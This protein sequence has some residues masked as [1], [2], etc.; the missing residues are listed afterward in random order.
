MLGLRAQNIL[1]HD[2]NPS[3]GPGQA[4]QPGKAAEQYRYYQEILFRDSGKGVPP[5]RTPGQYCYYHEMHFRGFGQGGLRRKG[6]RTNSFLPENAFQRFSEALARGSPPGKAPEQGCYYQEM[7]SRSSGQGVPPGRAPEQDSYAQER[8]QSKIFITRKCLP[9]ALA[10]GLPQER[11]QKKIVVARKCLRGS[12]GGSRPGKAPE[13]D[14][15]YLEMPSIGSGQG[16]PPGTALE[17]DRSHQAILSRGFGQ[18]V[19]RK[20]SRTRSLLPG[21]AFKKL[22]SE[23]PRREG[24]PW[25]PEESQ[26]E[27]LG[28][29]KTKKS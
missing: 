15:H 6:S 28:P 5:G 20:G 21:S 3:K 12:G 13:Q 9:E 2:E 11:H 25:N 16:V 17:Q 24:V 26:N 19:P 18:G 1:E 8:L 27:G 7:P 29:G 22:W 10:T 23:G 14:C 4:V